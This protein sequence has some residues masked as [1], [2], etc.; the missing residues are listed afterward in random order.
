[1]LEQLRQQLT[2]FWGEQSRSQRIV[3]VVLVG[4]G[5][6]LIPLFFI[7]A[8]T[9]S[10]A[11]AFSGLS[12]ADAGQ[13]VE[14][15]NEDNTLYQL[16]TGTILV[17]SD[18][19][20]DVRLQMARQGLP[21]GGSVGFELFSGSTLGMTEFSQRVNY[22]QA[23][24]GELERTIVNLNSVE[25]VRVHIVTPERSLLSSEQLLT[26]AAITVM[27]KPG[28]HLD[29]AQVR[30]I[31]HLVASSVEGLKPENVV[32]VDVNGNLLASGE[33]SITAQ[34]DSHRVT[35]QMAAR[36]IE[37]KV[38]DLLD[39]A[40]G[41]NKSVVQSQVTMDWT[42]KEVVTQSF[43]PDTTAVRSYQDIMETYTTTN[44]TLAGI[45]GAISNLP[46]AEEGVVG[47]NQ[48]VF[49][50]RTEE[51][52]NYE[53]TEV[54]SREVK[55]PGTIERISLS[56]LVDG[57]TDPV[58]LTTMKSV[59]SAAA[60]IDETRGDVLAVETLDFD[61]TYYEEQAE[62]LS[63]S[64]TRELY[65]KIG[66]AVTVALVVGALLWYVQ[67]LLKNLRLKSAEAWT[68]IL[69][70]LGEVALPTITGQLQMEGA[71]AGVP[72]PQVGTFLS[73]PAQTPQPGQSTE[74][75]PLAIPKVDTPV[76]TEEDEQLLKLIQ[77]LAEEE[78]ANLS[79]IIQLW[80]SEDE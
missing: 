8:S 52:T 45:P 59:I 51:I 41:P 7:W 22:Q 38:L 72:T 73:E 30:S 48:G 26:T 49:Y 71:G 57:I 17:P 20:Y 78:P 4:T 18:Q 79:N 47:E 9:P 13:I 76:F 12:E 56:V 63:D 53:V 5:I 80:L 37:R 27:E 36:E 64:Q 58:Q 2:A 68:P 46:P 55:A 44:A 60:G 1:M 67:R 14:K 15:L 16:R 74:P 35:E 69:K 10:Y 6:V 19:V 34:T 33:D 21:Q 25:A 28:T 75:K 3:L 31:T 62:D 54:E 40:L 29:A 24:E 61:R 23:L 70:P 77:E 50:K 32:V 43:N 66:Q 65:I 11:V 39:S 42:E